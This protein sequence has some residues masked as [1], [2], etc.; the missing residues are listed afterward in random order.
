[1]RAGFL[2]GFP[3]LCGFPKPKIEERITALK[4]FQYF[5]FQT[6]LK[7]GRAEPQEEIKCKQTN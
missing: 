6:W 2:M 4:V 1:M 5:S 3:V 7:P